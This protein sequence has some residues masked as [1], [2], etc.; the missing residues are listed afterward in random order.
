MLDVQPTRNKRPYDDLQGSIKNKVEK[1]ICMTAIRNQV[2]K[3]E[4]ESELK[5]MLSSTAIAK[6][7]ETVTVDRANYPENT[8]MQYNHKQEPGGNIYLQENWH[9]DG[10]IPTRTKHKHIDRKE[11]RYIT[12]YLKAAT[13]LLTILAVL[14]R[15]VRQQ[16]TRL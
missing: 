3:M 5:E 15:L 14:E 16:S 12:Y 4:T 11:T 1:V 6:W 9:R 8:M 13:L 7:L 10:V 2:D